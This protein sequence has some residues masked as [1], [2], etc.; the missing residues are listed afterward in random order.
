MPDPSEG[1]RSRDTGAPPTTRPQFRAAAC[2]VTAGRSVTYKVD[3]RAR[4][5]YKCIDLGMGLANFVPPS[6]HDASRR[7]GPTRG[8]ARGPAERAATSRARDM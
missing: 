6:R 4:R 3:Q 7:E 1:S 2:E 5:R 8:L